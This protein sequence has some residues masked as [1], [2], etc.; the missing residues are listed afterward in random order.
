MKLSAVIPCFS[1]NEELKNMAL[2][3]AQSIRNQVDELIIT[4][5]ADL[6]WP[7]LHQ[8]S[9]IY[10]LHPR[11][12]YKG[13]CNLGW[14]IA[15][16]DFIA[17]V[18]SDAQLAEGNLS[19]LCINGIGVPTILGLE[20]E[21]HTSQAVGVFFVTPQKLFKTVGGWDSL[22]KEESGTGQWDWSL[23]QKFERAGANRITIKTVKVGHPRGG[24]T[25]Y[26][27]LNTYK[28]R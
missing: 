18:N 7:E 20:N 19:E 21:S 11:L 8:I 1:I 25:S 5:D 6:Y 17:Q 22:D 24:A 4:E 2:T 3:C 16:G 12:G 15:T 10:L 13:N 27:Y 14:S 9:D 28:G 23:F 26:R